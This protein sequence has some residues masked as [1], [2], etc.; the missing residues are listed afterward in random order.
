[1]KR[2][3]IIIHSVTGNT[4]IIADHLCKL[5]REGGVDARLYRVEDPDLHILANEN[6]RTNEFLEDLLAIP[7]VKNEKLLKS[8]AVVMGCPTYFANVSAEMK[9][10]IDGTIGYY[11]TGDM[12]GRLF[13]AFTSCGGGLDDAKKAIAAMNTW[14][15]QMEMELLP[16]EP[17]IHI[18]GE[19]GGI[20]PSVEFGGLIGS[21]AD[22]I[23]KALS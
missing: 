14:A 3:S 20:R 13:A 12:N 9:A 19:E 11:G 8:D 1:M 4:F 23:L 15:L 18:S 17:L 7:V 10:F 6:E 2:C 16:V 22:V 5:L 21:F